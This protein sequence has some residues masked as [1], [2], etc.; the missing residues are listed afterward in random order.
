[1]YVP[2]NTHILAAEFDYVQPATL[3][4]VFSLL[5]EHGARAQLIAGGTDLLVQMKMEQK[6]PACLISLSRIQELQG[7]TSRGDFT[8]GATASIWS[9]AKSKEV[10]LQ[11]T[12][13]AEACEAFTSVPIMIMGTLGGNLCNASPAAKTA[14]PLL[15]FDATVS[16]ASRG[17]RRDVPLEDFF[18]GPGQT[19]L[20]ENEVL[21]SVRL[22]KPAPKTGSA[23]LKVGRVHA[24]IAQVS[25]AVR[26]VLD[27][28]QVIDCRIALGAVGPT[29][30]RA[31][32][33]EA[34]LTDR[35]VDSKGVEEV[36][37]IAAE[38]VKP[39]V[40]VRAT[41]EYRRRVSGV[42]VRDALT[43]AWQRAG[44]GRLK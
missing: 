11:C 4:E 41:A 17:G 3:A 15:A 21:H 44:G 12:A 13:L 42:I 25:A 5:S 31:R 37:R 23:F 35:K 29:P 28:D 20:G 24:D 40:D 7:I 43:A 14:P 10:R 32:R 2:T 9:L 27:G 34:F 33:A 39:I 38:E 22:A 26:L 1:M 19:V 36:A 18:L 8:A 16:L 6:S 30:M